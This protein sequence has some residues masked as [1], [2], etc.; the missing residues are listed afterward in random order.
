MFILD[1][2]SKNLKSLLKCQWTLNT[3]LG[4]L[5]V[6]DEET[7]DGKLCR[8]CMIQWHSIWGEAAL[9][10]QHILNLDIMWCL[11][12][13]VLYK[14]KGGFRVSNLLIYLLDNTVTSDIFCGIPQKGIE[15]VTKLFQKTSQIRKNLQL[16]VCRLVVSAEAGEHH[17]RKWRQEGPWKRCSSTTNSA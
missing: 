11:F 6:T 17:S 4:W 15:Q 2:S 8:H 7:K 16:L 5:S 13:A 14:T 9:G 1:R 3:P 12:S 10:S